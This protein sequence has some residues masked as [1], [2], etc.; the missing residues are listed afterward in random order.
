MGLGGEASHLRHEVERNQKDPDNGRITLIALII[1]AIMT[2]VCV[3]GCIS[4]DAERQEAIDAAEQTEETSATEEEIQGYPSQDNW[5]DEFVDD[6]YKAYG[7]QQGYGDYN[8][9][10]Y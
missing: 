9:G 1:I 3:V 7:E 4:E 6:A 5:Q 8:E 2:L 10:P